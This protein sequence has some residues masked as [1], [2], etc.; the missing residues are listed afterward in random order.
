VAGYVK[1]SK[2]D[3]ATGKPREELGFVPLNHL[4]F[5]EVAKEEE[6]LGSLAEVLWPH[7]DAN[8]AFLSAGKGERVEVLREDSG[9]EGW[10]E[11]ALGG[12]R[13]LFPR[14]YLALASRSNSYVSLAQLLV[15]DPS[16]ELVRSMGTA[17]KATSA[18]RCGRLLLEAFAA[19]QQELRLLRACVDSEVAC[20]TSEGTL[21]RRNSINSV[22]MAEYARSIG[23]E[24]L[25]LVL[26]PT[27]DKVGFGRESYELDPAKIVAPDTV[28]AGVANIVARC[29]ELL[30]RLI[31]TVPQMPPQI[32]YIC[33]ALATAVAEK[34]P[35]ARHVA[36]G[37]F[38]MLRFICPVIA[39]NMAG[40][41][42]VPPERRRG[43]VLISKALINLVNDVEFGKKEPYMTPLEG[44]LRQTGTAKLHAFFDA[45]CRLGGEFRVPGVVSSAVAADAK[46]M[47]GLQQFLE[48]PS[49]QNDL[50]KQNPA[51]FA[52]LQRAL[53]ECPPVPAKVVEE[54]SEV[55]K[56]YPKFA[57]DKAALGRELTALKK[58]RDQEVA[59]QTLVPVVTG[60]DK[61][62]VTAELAQASEEVR[63]L[64]QAV[65]AMVAASI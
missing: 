44:P 60:K 19:N 10:S 47:A 16:L 59:L 62:K 4:V 2:Y 29:E 65:N 34:M 48:D 61:K 33:W 6:A 53:K 56:L 26:Q 39:A 11:C 5:A 13:G 32:A 43:L 45:A 3:E 25:R 22:A 28:G 42:P 8:R 37:G 38:V 58:A 7:R 21:F 17:V 18:D 27:L 46:C 12:V 63:R 23:S 54:P 24:Y 36:V 35:Q 52:R 40:L 15:A 1:V 49:A 9:F 51:L 41:A 64:E 20:S 55:E 14:P 31:S 30:E 50:A 57:G